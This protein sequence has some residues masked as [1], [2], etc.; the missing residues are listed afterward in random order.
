MEGKVKFKKAIIG[1][2]VFLITFANLNFGNI[3]PSYGIS[4]FMFDSTGWKIELYSHWK[5]SLNIDSSYYLTSLEDTAYFSIDT[6]K[7]FS[8]NGNEYDPVLSVITNSS[9]YSD[10]EINE[11]QDTIRIHGPEFYVDSLQENESIGNRSNQIYFGFSSFPPSPDKEQSICYY[12]NSPCSPFLDNSPTIGQVNDNLD[13]QAAL[14]FSV[15]DSNEEPLEDISIYCYRGYTYVHRMGSSD[16]NGELLV[17]FISGKHAF[18]FSPVDTLIDEMRFYQKSNYIKKHLVIYPETTKTVDVQIPDSILS[19]V[20]FPES[21]P[22]KY[23]LSDNYPNPFNSSTFFTYQIPIDDYVEI[24]LYDI[25]GRL[26]KNLE[27][28]FKTAG[29]YKID[30]V[31][32][33]LNSG[34]FFYR[35]E[36]GNKTITKKCMFLK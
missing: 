33:N 16:Q 14:E 36:T 17:D 13:A 24:N 34:I 21:I 7:Y 18:I 32:K 5:D 22:E 35:L 29:K 6:L 25:R 2:F 31:A 28:G 3:M 8:P 10:L 4:E 19:Q 15:Y 1:Y 30:F 27:S 12:L 11:R 9:L 26:I 20:N 23:K